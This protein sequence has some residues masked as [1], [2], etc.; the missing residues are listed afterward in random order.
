MQEEIAKEITEKLRLTLTEK[1][2]RLLTKRYTENTEAYHL[3]LRGR[4]YASMRNPKDLNNGLEYFRQAIEIDPLY[5]PAYAGVADCYLNMGYMFGRVPPTD[6]LPKA[7][8]SALRALD[9]DDTLAEAYTSL[10]MVNFTFEW[11][12]A[13]AKRHFEK[14]IELNPNLPAA[15]HSYGAYLPQCWGGDDAGARRDG[16]VP[17]R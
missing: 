16:L 7:K 8:A 6:A 13:N 4:F 11:D 14:S 12:M 3:Y 9:I 2:Q 1:E 10:A 15:H 17:S 5:A